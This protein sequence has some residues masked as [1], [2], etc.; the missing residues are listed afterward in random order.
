MNYL[1]QITEMLGIE[2]GERFILKEKNWGKLTGEYYLQ[3]DGL[4]CDWK[5]YNH[6]HHIKK[7]NDIIMKIITGEYVIEKKPWKPE[8][9]EVYCYIYTHDGDIHSSIWE[10]DA[11]DIVVLL[12]GNC[13]RTEEEAEAA[14]PEIIAKMD[15]ILSGELVLAERKD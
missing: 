13:F 4:Y 7:S 15:R 12:M 9:G 14:A 10:G 2:I 3:D 1:K 6:Q 11:F 8:T 5:D